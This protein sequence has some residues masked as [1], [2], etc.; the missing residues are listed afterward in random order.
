M[1]LKQQALYFQWRMRR[2]LTF[3][4]RIDDTCRAL[5]EIFLLPHELLSL[6]P[7][8]YSPEHLFSLLQLIKSYV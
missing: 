6:L 7:E 3:L 4:F 1:R 2:I 5:L 8:Y